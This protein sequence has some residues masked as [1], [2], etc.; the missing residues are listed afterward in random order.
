MPRRA[1]A[2]AILV[3][4]V[5]L[6]GCVPEPTREETGRTPAAS[7]TSSST[8]A[9]TPVETPDAATAEFVSVVD[10]DTI[11][12]S[13]GTV[14]IIGIDTPERGECG[15]DAASAVFGALFAAGDPV[16]LELP[17]GQNDRD[18]HGR[19]LRFVTTA[20]GIDI[21]LAQLQAG[22]A[23]ARYD[24]ADGY[25]AHPREADY[26]AAQLATL[27]ADG[28]VVA[29]GCQVEVAPAPPAP[30]DRWWEQYSSCTKLKKNA[31]GH[32]VGPFLRDDPA[33]AEAYDWFANRTGNNGDGDGD[34]LAC[35]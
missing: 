13:E 29:V 30:T 7:A 3:A 1:A 4:V 28:R 17:P 15:H 2:A 27:S 16:V 24:S 10:G 20:G 5:A 9:N 14:R 18:R 11:E 21:G 33:Q 23:V 22:S 6:A 19:L 31:L 25:P 8:P 12:T 34:G 32:P 26:R 35:E